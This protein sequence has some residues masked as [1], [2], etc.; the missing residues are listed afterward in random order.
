MKIEN[1]LWSLLF[2]YCKTE[3]DDQLAQIPTSILKNS[4]IYYEEHFQ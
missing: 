3:R 2:S 1:N 4:E